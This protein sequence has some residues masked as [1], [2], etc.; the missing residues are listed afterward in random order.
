MI[1]CARRYAVKNSL[2]CC[3]VSLDAQ[4]AFDS[5]DHEYL[6]KVMEAYEFPQEFIEVFQTLYSGLK[7]VVQVNGFLSQEFDVLRG[8]KQ[9]DALSCGLLC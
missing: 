9:G 6:I 5:V 7:S 4:K 2:D 8:V 3:V 1:Q